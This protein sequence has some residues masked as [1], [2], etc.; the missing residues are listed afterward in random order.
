MGKPMRDQPQEFGA[1]DEQEGAGKRTAMVVPDNVACYR[2][3][4]D[5]PLESVSLRR[6]GWQAT[7]LTSSALKLPVSSYHNRRWGPKMAS[8]RSKLKTAL[9]NHSGRSARAAADAGQGSN[10]VLNRQEVI[11]GMVHDVTSCSLNTTDLPETIIRMGFTKMRRR[12]VES[13]HCGLRFR[14]QHLLRR[15]LPA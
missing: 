6:L 3:H 1:E 9:D 12:I 11:M 14:L 13:R 5:T 8:S 10:F 7:R 15:N 4:V 2:T